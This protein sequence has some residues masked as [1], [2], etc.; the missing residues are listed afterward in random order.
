LAKTTDRTGREWLYV[1]I[2]EE[3]LLPENNIIYKENKFPT[4]LTDGSGVA[5]SGFCNIS[6]G[7][8]HDPADFSVIR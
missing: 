8:C 2:D 7:M 1:E 5:T 4:K 3:Y 6:T